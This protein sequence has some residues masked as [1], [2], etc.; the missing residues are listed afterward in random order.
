MEVRISEKKYGLNVFGIPSPSFFE[1]YREHLV[2]PF[3]VFQVLCLLL[4]SLD[5][6]WYLL[7]TYPLSVLLIYSRSVGIIQ[8]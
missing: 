1:L 8:C 2:A 6:Y 5:D 3:F 7:I 4:W